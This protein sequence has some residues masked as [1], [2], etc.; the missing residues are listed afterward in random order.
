[1]MD[2]T[3]ICEL[4][5]PARDR[6]WSLG[7][8]RPAYRISKVL[9]N[10]VEQ[11]AS[12]SVGRRRCAVVVP[13]GYSDVSECKLLSCQDLLTD[14]YSLVTP[15]RLADLLPLQENMSLLPVL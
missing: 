13:P 6:L 5:N 11:S 4:R 7:E 9:R 15:E 14:P 8:Q 10:R 2:A 1:M 3:Q 12:V